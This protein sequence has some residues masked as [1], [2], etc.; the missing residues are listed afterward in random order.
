MERRTTSTLRRL[1]VAATLGAPAG[2]A[3][4]EFIGWEVQRLGDLGA[5]VP[6][7]R[8]YLNFDSPADQLLAVGGDA[9][10]APFAL[11][12]DDGAELVNEAGAFD[13]L[14]LED[15]PS[16]LAAPW[17][18]W[19]TIGNDSAI[20]ND[21]AFSPGFLGGGDG[22]SVIHGSE[23]LHADN[24]GWFDS[25]P[26][27]PNGSGGSVLIAQLTFEGPWFL[28]EGTA[29]WNDGSS[30]LL[31]EGAFLMAVPAPAAAWGV[32]LVLLARR[33]RRPA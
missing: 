15:V 13:G 32:T 5:G 8:F 28:L 30:G 6:T 7:W 22:T 26:G 4:A 1:L 24:G 10:V 12:L 2:G 17:D 20:G 18:S 21:T 14:D 25:D 9:N 3:S 27:T 11:H 19:V 29:W 33:R 23:L 16:V 31:R